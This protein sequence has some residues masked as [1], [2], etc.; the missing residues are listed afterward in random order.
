MLGK[1]ES[2]EIWIYRKMMRI[3]WTKKVRNEDVYRRINTEELEE[4]SWTSCKK[5]Q[6]EAGFVDGK[7][8]RVDNGKLSSVH[9]Q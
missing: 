8:A 4:I 2:V 3:S 1:L 7:E 5:I 6:Y 9:R